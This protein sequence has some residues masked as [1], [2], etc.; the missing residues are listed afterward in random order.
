MPETEDSLYQLLGEANE[1]SYGDAKDAL[2]EQILRHAEA[3]EHAEVAFNTRLSLVGAYTHGLQPAKL[4]VPFARCLADYDRNPAA[5]EPWVAGTLRWYFKHAVNAMTKF[6]EVPKDR[7]L[8]ALDQMEDRYRAE[9]QSLQAVYSYRHRVAEHIGDRA[10]AEEWYE[11]WCATPRDDNSDCEG[12]DPSSKADYLVEHGRDAEAIAVAEPLL[13]GELTCVEQ[14]QRIL[15]TLLLPYLRTGQHEQARNAHRRAY[16]IL[17]TK[18]QDLADIGEHLVFCALSGNPSRGLE[19]LDRHLGWLDRAPSPSAAMMFAASAALLLRTVVEAGHDEAVVRRP[20]HGDRPAAEHTA[21]ALGAELTQQALD[22]AARFDRRNGTDQQ[23]K[24]VRTLIAR[25]RIVEHLPLSATAKHQP[26]STAPELVAADVSGLSATEL[27]ERAE[28]AYD[29]YERATATPLLQQ[30]DTLDDSALDAS[31][32]ARTAALR[33][34]LRADADDP[35]STEALIRRA[36]ELF[37][38]ADDETGRQVNLGHLGLHLCETD[39]VD[40]GLALVR[41]SHAYLIQRPDR[42]EQIESTLRLVEALQIAAGGELA[43]ETA[44]LLAAATTLAAGSGDPVLI[45]DVAACQMDLP[46]YNAEQLDAG[47]GAARTALAAYRSAEVP[48]MIAVAG[49]RLGALLRHSGDAESAL[50]AVEE[51]AAA[52]RAVEPVHLRVAVYGLRGSLLNQLDRPAEAVH[53]LLT[54]IAIGRSVDSEAVP[55]CLWDLAIAYHRTGQLLDAADL[56][57]EAVA[58]FDALGRTEESQSC[59]WLLAGLHRD[60]AEPDQALAIYDDIIEFHRANDEH[61][62]AAQVLAETA[63]LLDTLDRDALAAQRYRQAGDAAALDD[64]P[65]R[66][67][68][69][70]YSEAMSLR[71]SGEIDAAV[72]ALDAA[73]QAMRD[74]AASDPDPD[75]LTWHQARLDQNAARILYAADRSDAALDRAAKAATMFRT[76]D[77]T[78]NAA[79]S[80]LLHG[81]ILLDLERAA[82]A[83]EVL[84]K[85]LAEVEED[86]PVHEVLTGALATARERLG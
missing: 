41:T 10:A 9:G 42:A 8:A 62:A 70:R 31:L 56:A 73:E 72:A 44:E 15:T 77:A 79:S 38:T 28:H 29:R 27:V 48:K 5:Y 86:D 36:V 47:I 1:L 3:G 75:L 11:K 6:P 67:A 65:V 22:I 60:M 63:D 68:Y 46:I 13:A 69:C 45:G 12:C 16:R 23:S 4:F 71:W 55:R 64:D 50:T 49:F 61:G 21:A 43:D 78:D 20:A 85:A 74:L 17:R 80:D 30:L 57:E 33:A 54:A 34:R 18:P 81:R 7:A 24:I 2:L 52:L 26:P 32:L 40:E 37:A 53:E 66:V 83:A 59:R 39:R 19:L 58:A 25:E 51:A 35:A 76:I 84:G 14:P 82:E